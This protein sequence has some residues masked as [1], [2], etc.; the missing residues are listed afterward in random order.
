M[1]DFLRFLISPLLSFPDELVISTQLSTITI[2]VADGDVGRLIGK[3]GSVINALRT[4]TK[5]YCSSHTH[6][7]VT[8][9]LDSPP[10]AA[11]VTKTDSK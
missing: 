10:L 4:L 2:K 3:H 11:P 1:E 7:Q 8:L 5:T 9:V 6:P